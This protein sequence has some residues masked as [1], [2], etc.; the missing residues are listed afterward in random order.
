MQPLDLI[1]K[2]SLYSRR[3]LTQRRMAGQSRES[4]CHELLHDK[5]GIHITTGKAL[6]PLW[7]RGQKNCRNQV[8]KNWRKQ[9][10]LTRSG[11]AYLGLVQATTAALIHE[12]RTAQRQA[13]QHFSMEYE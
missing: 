2:V 9:C 5:W 13:S 10:L 8:E 11:V 12:V 1:R 6:E 7:K 3:W 4:K